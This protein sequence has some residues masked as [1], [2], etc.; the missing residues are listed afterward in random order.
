[1]TIRLKYLLSVSLAFSCVGLTVTADEKKVETQ[2]VKIKDITLKVPKSWESKPNSSSMR[3]ATYQIPASGGDDV[4]GEL[5]V[6]NFAGGGGDIAANL[7]RWVGQFDSEGRTVEAKSGT[8]GD[9]KYVISTITGTYHKPIGP[10]IRRQTE[11]VAGYRMVNVIL[12]LPD[13]N[14]YYL[15]MVGPDATIKAQ[16]QAFRASFGGDAE[17]ETEYEI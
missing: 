12:T 14:V 1:M 8:V 6:F 9:K 17:Q 3:L 16:E 5:T 2:E 11:D 13:G 7:S 4:P 15:K 10:P